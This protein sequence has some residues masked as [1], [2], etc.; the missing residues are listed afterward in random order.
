MA[1]PPQLDSTLPVNDVTACKFA[2]KS[3]FHC[4]SGECVTDPLLSVTPSGCETIRCK[5]GYHCDGGKCYEDAVIIIDPIEVFTPPLPVDAE[6]PTLPFYH[7]CTGVTC[8]SGNHCENGE[9]VPDSTDTT[10]PES[11]GCLVSGDM[12]YPPGQSTGR[13][14]GLTCMGKDA[15][16]GIETICGTDGSLV[17]VANT[18]QCP[19][20]SPYCVQC[21]AEA[22]CVANIDTY[23]CASGGASNVIK[24]SPSHMILPPPDKETT[25]NNVKLPQSSSNCKKG[26]HFKRGKGC[27]L[28]KGCSKTKP[29]RDNY[30]CKKNK[31][32]ENKDHSCDYVNCGINPAFKCVKG[33]CVEEGN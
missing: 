10:T 23:V 26:F 19:S 3:G 7:N 25:S 1:E 14:V 17:E 4:E 33:K 5:D 11:A 18:F 27:L 9:C 31:C 28:N 13:I 8:F 15:F 16:K 24:E 12:M 20:E 2:C 32:V 21:G 29:C 30:T 22:I 6:V